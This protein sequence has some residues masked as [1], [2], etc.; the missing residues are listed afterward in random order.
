[1][2]HNTT[3]LQI[4]RKLV[5]QS[6][7]EAPPPKKKCK[8]N[9][10]LTCPLDKQ[11]NTLV[12]SVLSNLPKGQVELRM[13]QG[14]QKTHLPTGQ[15]I[16]HACSFSS[17]QL[18]QMT[19]KVKSGTRETEDSLAHWTSGSQSFFLALLVECKIPCSAQYLF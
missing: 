12:L 7:R 13:G 1:M 11:Y 16:K 15:A 8:G 17:F 3:L 14:R 19:S 10:R 5:E 18:A 6:C 9:R 2:N 4:I